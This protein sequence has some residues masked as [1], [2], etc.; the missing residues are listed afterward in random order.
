MLAVMRKQLQL[1]SLLSQPHHSFEF[2]PQ[3][4]E[5]FDRAEIVRRRHRDDAIQ[6]QNIFRKHRHRGSGLI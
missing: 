3:L 6:A 1:R 4:F 5:N 2:K